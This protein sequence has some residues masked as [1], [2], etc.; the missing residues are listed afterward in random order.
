MNTMRQQLMAVSVAAALVGLQALA[1]PPAAPAPA[2]GAAE[3]GDWIFPFEGPAGYGFV[4][5]RGS[6][7]TQPQYAAV[8]YVGGGTYL[9]SSFA[10]GSRLGAERLLLVEGRN[11]KATPLPTGFSRLAWQSQ[12][13][14]LHLGAAGNWVVADFKGAYK[15]SPAKYAQVMAFTDGLAAVQAADTR[16][17]GFVDLTGR[18]VVPTKWVGVINGFEQGAAMVQ[19]QDRRTVIDR[20]GRELVSVG[21]DERTGFPFSDGLM[22]VPDPHAK[23]GAADARLW[24][25]IDL[26]GKMQIRPQFAA[27][28]RF[29]EGLAPVKFGTKWGVIDRDGKIVVQAQFDDCSE[30]S[31]G[32]AAVQSKAKWG[33][34]NKTGN[35]V[36]PCVY[37]QV[38][39]FSEGLAVVE[40]GGKYGFIDTTGRVAL[41]PAYDVVSPF[42]HGVAL[43][44]NGGVSTLPEDGFAAT[45]V[46]GGTWA[47]VNR[48]GRVVYQWQD[49]GGAPAGSKPYHGRVFPSWSG[50]E[51]AAT[52]TPAA[53]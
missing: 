45:Y 29:R 39:L 10:E 51:P 9:V 47:Y 6:V 20:T 40:V 12:V 1:A 24:G 44:N 38:G 17:W 52:P 49:A 42:R 28:G 14:W 18:L 21:E 13:G 27:T 53:P 41:P 30:F 5:V 36:I 26:K 7:V 48:Q 32:F 22:A 46:A 4:D 23:A 37:E 19:S 11:G 33:F 35:V 2:P 3:S 34:I 43:T 16:K 50:E 15:S 31:E 25:Y 8:Q